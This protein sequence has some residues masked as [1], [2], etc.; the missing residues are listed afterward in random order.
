MNING[1]LFVTKIILEKDKIEQFNNYPFNIELI[2][3]FTELNLTSPVTFL[4]GENGVGKST[5]IEGLAIAL[6][7]NPEG[8]TQNFMFS[9]KDTHSNLHQFIKVNHFQ[10]MCKTKFFLRAESFYNFAFEVD[11]LGVSGYGKTSLHSCSH[12]ESFL[13]LVQNR[14]TK[15]GLYILDEPEA[16]LSPQRQ[17]SYFV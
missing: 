1:K 8:G 6:D 10:R 15:D 16:A 17:M 13:Q 5:F 9:S 11:K 12:G 4:I 2:K 3:N 7:L 14:F